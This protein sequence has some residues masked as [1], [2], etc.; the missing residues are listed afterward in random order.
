MPSRRFSPSLWMVLLLVAAILVPTTLAASRGDRISSTRNT[1]NDRRAPRPVDNLRVASSDASGVTLD[2]SR[3]WDNVGVEGYGVYLDGARKSETPYT[4]YRLSDLVCG[5]GYTVGVDAFDDAGNR[6]RATSTIV[7]TAACGD[8]TAPSIPTGVH[9]VA[10]T[11]T[12]VILAW[13]PS[14]DDF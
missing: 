7:S 3:A 9:S 8:V 2:W 12:S 13:T 14:S 1:Y 4:N 10:A 6:S 11:E 5:K